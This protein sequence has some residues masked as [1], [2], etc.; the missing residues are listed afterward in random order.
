MLGSATGGSAE[1]CAAV[2]D[3]PPEQD[4]GE[5]GPAGGR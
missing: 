1:V 4:G 3:G 5:K 2:H